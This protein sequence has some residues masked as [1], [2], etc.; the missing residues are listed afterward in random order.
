MSVTDGVYNVASRI[1]NTAFS[2]P[3]S[4]RALTII[5]LN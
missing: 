2:L 1:L 4:R 3:E 5:L